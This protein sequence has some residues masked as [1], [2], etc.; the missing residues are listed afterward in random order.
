MRRRGSCRYGRLALLV[1]AAIGTAAIGGCRSASPMS[2]DPKREVPG[3]DADR[4]K[5]DIAA[6]GCGSCHTIPGVRG[7]KGLV[8]PPLIKFARRTFIAG[9]VPNTAEYL[10]R[11][12]EMP[13]AIEP[14]TAMPNLG[15]S[16]GRARDIAAYL[17]T[18]R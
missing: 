17:Y 8:G 12:I 13:Q 9:E 18:L 3:G 7:A 5:R 1:A 14:G 15:V 16:E 2:A 11:W 4:G 10:V 6:F